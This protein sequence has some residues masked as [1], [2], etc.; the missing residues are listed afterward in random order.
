MSSA[1]ISLT[2]HCYLFI[3]KSYSLRKESTGLATAARMDW[4]LMV[5]QAISR[6]MPPA[7]KKVLAPNEIRYSKSASHSFIRKYATGI[8]TSRAI[9]TS[10]VKSLEKLTTRLLTDAPITLRI[11]ISLVRC[12]AVYAAKPNNPRQAIKIAREQKIVKIVPNFCSA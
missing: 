4:K 3:V 8:A 10:F 5:N 2:A 11:P 1:V 12:S 6:A 9:N 7:I